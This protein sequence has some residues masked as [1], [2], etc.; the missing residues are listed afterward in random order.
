MAKITLQGNPLN[1]FGDLPETGMI[2]PDSVLVKKDLSEIRISDLKGRKL[3]LNIFPSI[4]TQVCAT[5]VRKFNKE[6][7]EIKNTS[8]LCIS[9]D[10]PFAHARFCGAEGIDRVDSLSDFRT[11]EFGKKYGVEIIDGPLAGLLAR[12]VVVLDENGTVIYSELVPETT[13]EPD[14][15]AALKAAR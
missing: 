7:A 12:S 13:S 6:A 11:G 14:Y 1:T 15:E 5:S 2:A 10:L 3:I 9:R 8:V 4:D